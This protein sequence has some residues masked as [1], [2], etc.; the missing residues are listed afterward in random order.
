M[1]ALAYRPGHA[2]RY[3][4]ARDTGAHETT[5]CIDHEAASCPLVAVKPAPT[6][7]PTEVAPVDR[8]LLRG[9]FQEQLVAVVVPHLARLKLP[10]GSAEAWRLVQDVISLLKPEVRRRTIAALA[11]RA[12]T[13]A[14]AAERDGR[15]QEAWAW[16]DRKNWLVAVREEQG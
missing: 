6:P 5:V 16:W 9:P 8:A 11:D 4:W 3:E 1:T 7:E 14:E 2:G 13:E 12:T 10:E 15:E